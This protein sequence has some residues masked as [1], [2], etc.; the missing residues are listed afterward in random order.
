MNI[1]IKRVTVEPIAM[2]AA[3]YL[4]YAL[5]P[6]HLPALLS[7][8]DA[9]PL[10][11]LSTANVMTLPGAKRA[12][13]GNGMPPRCSLKLSR[14]EFACSRVNTDLPPVAFLSAYGSNNTNF[15]IFTEVVFVGSSP[16]I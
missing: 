14:V 11:P 9:T 16:F 12:Q 15:N 5:L 4:E 3:T 1:R 7:A 6:S 2:P 8:F 10:N 13:Q